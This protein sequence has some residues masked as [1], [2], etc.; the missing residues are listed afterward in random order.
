M[1]RPPLLLSVDIPQLQIRGPRCP[2]CGRKPAGGA[3]CGG[4]LIACSSTLVCANGHGYSVAPNAFVAE[5]VYRS[6]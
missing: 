4:H 1:N 3:V 2:E 5:L 6:P